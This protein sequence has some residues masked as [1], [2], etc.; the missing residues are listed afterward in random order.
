MFHKPYYKTEEG[1]VESVRVLSKSPGRTTSRDTLSNVQDLLLLLQLGIYQSIQHVTFVDVRSK[2]GMYTLNTFARDSQLA[3]MLQNTNS[4]TL[5]VPWRVC[6]E[7]WTFCK[8][9]NFASTKNS[10]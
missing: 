5:M 10:A 6:L 3:Q 1:S 7:P 8:S 2:G 4:Q 9:M